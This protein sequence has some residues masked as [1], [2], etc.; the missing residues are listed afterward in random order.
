[1]KSSTYHFHKKTEILADFQICISVPLS[2]GSTDAG[3]TEQEIIY[4]RLLDKEL[5]APTK[6]VDIIHLEKANS[7]SILNTIHESI[8]NFHDVNFK[9]KVGD[10]NVEEAHK[11][12]QEKT[13]KDFYEKVV[14]CNFDGASVMSGKRD[15]VQA[16][17]M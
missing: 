8:K 11:E 6:F 3:A 15:G 7:E 17:K 2:D 16:K 4:C 14:A 5:K 9:Q 12:F 13:V 1:M 10:E